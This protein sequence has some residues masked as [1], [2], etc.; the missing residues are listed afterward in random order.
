MF[1]AM[2]WLQTPQWSRWLAAGALVLV[3]AWTELRPDP[4]V[5]HPFALVDIAPGVVVDET[6][7]EPRSLPDGALDRVDLGFIA[8]RAIYAGSPVLPAD[9]S[10]SEEFVPPGWWIVAVELPPQ[11][12][13]GNDVKIVLLD[14]GETVDG[15]IA[16]QASEDTFG[17]VTG[18]VAVPSGPAGEVAAAAAQGRVSVLVSSG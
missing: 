3:A 10:V 11:V 8:R 18:G 7:T 9:V 17:V 5:T 6:N 12:A 16:S 1:V 15:V 4:V 13:I 2:L 14:T